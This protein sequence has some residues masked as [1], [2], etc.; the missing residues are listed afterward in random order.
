MAE[1]ALRREKRRQSRERWA[2]LSPAQRLR[3]AASITAAARALRAAGRASV[4]RERAQGGG[5]PLREIGEVL[6]LLAGLRIP[7][8]LIGGWAVV[9]S[10]VLRTSDDIDLLADFSAAQRKALLEG[11]S[12]RYEAQWRA[13]GHDDPIAGLIRAAPRGDGLPVDILAAKGAADRAALARARRVR[14]GDMVLTV[15]RPEDLVAMKLA[16]GGGQDYVDARS[17]LGLPGGL[18]EELL[19]AAC[20]ERRVL[21]RLALIRAR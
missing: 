11:L 7:H 5:S 16:A 19:L 21:E 1:S 10:G 2:K 13:P 8:A 18:D 3:R 12:E 4:V 15:A 20:G 17:L 6:S 14:A 9:A